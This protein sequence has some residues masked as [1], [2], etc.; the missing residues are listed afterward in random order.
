[1]SLPKGHKEGKNHH[2]RCPI[3]ILRTHHSYLT[4]VLQSFVSRVISDDTVKESK[5]AKEK[6]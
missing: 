6:L 4:Y 5:L 1:M 3:A 2:K